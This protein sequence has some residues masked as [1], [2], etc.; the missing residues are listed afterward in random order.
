MKY[1][2]FSLWGDKPIYNIGVIKNAELMDVYYPDWKMVVYFD[3]TVPEKT[4]EILNEKKVIT[5]NISN[6]TIYGMF[7]RFFALDIQIVNMQFSGIPIQEY[8]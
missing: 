7:W 6:T 4:I 2:S 5:K 1:V 3:N 8:H